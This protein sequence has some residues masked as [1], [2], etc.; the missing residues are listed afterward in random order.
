MKTYF[1]FAAIMGLFLL[2]MPLLSQA[3]SEPEGE[4]SET[5]NSIGAFAGFTGAGRREN[6]L[7]L[8]LTYERRITESFGIGA[9]AERVSGDLDFWLV[10]VPFAYHRGAW[11]LFAGPGVEKL[12]GGDYEGLVRIGGEYGFEISEKWEI[13]P[14][15]AFDFIDGDTEVIGGVLFNYH[16]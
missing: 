14:V 6:G 12:D 8:A 13:S 3:E 7:T 1:S 4:R 5:M 16:F 10:T 11:K 15:L 9:E 2:L